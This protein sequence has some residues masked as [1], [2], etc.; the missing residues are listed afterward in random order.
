MTAVPPCRIAL[1]FDFGRARIGVAVGEAVTGSARPLRT[2][3]TRQQR[4]DWDVIARLIAEW[5]PDLLVIGVPR[6]ADDSANAMTAAALR[7]SRQLHGRFNLPV[8]TIDE[9]LSSWEA[10]QRYFATAPAGRRRDH[11]PALDAQAAAVIL[12]SWF[13]QQR[14]LA[15]C[16]KPNF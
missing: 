15:P 14:S 6:H 2:L 1:G 3:P 5:R 9:R 7:F 10:E 11:D 8:A 16:V 4:P 13:N 12:E